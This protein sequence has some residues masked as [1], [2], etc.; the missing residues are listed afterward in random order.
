MRHFDT[1]LLRDPYSIWHYYSTGRR[2]QET[3]RSMIQERQICAP[4]VD[5]SHDKPSPVNPYALEMASQE[6]CMFL[7]KLPAEIRLMIYDYLFGDET[8]HLVQ[9]KG[10]IRHVRCTHPSTSIVSNRSCCPVTTARWRVQD[11]RVEDHAQSLLYPH[12]HFSLPESLSNSSL[13][14]LRTCRA[15]YAEASNI[16]YSNLAFD[17]DDLHTFIA[18]S[19]T[20]N[21]EHLRCIK[22]LTVQWMPVWQP[23]KGE[24]QQS[25]VFS[26]THNDQLWALF[27]SRVAALGGLEELQLCLDLGRFSGNL[28]GGG[29]I[30]GRR[31]NLAIDQPWIAPMLQVRGLRSFDLG[32]TAKCDLRAKQVIE[33]DLR[34]DAVTLRDLLQAILCSSPDQP[35]H[36]FN[37][38]IPNLKKPCSTGTFDERRIRPR[39]AITSS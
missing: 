12:T 39:L 23:M 37:L 21:Q 5:L 36:S 33:D 29:V 3:I 30:G 11:A 31:L 13:S 14:L 26:H 9:L 22:R 6:D 16:L 7:R 38:N 8:V 1:W 34:R 27:W 15:I 25:S 4:Q 20:V 32:I 19:L 24:V 35:L 17:V 2:W 18:F 28:I 10:K